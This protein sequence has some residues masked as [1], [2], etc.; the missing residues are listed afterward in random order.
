MKTLLALVLGCAF[1][2]PSFGLDSTDRLT[3]ETQAVLNTQKQ[4]VARWAADPVLVAAV[5]AQN[6]KGPLP[7]MTNRQ[8]RGLAP[9]DPTVQALQ[10]N[11]AGVWLTKKMAA[12]NGLFREAFLS[13]AKG[14]KVA[15]VEKPS[16]YLHAGM[17]KFDVPMSGQIW[18]GQP[19]FDKSSR[20]HVVQIAVPVK[21]SGKPIGVLVV[22]VSMKMMKSGSR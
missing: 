8:W 10:K 12:N 9:G 20:S 1:A 3:P 14:E 7:G 21:S 16:N 11:A 2:S 5:K 13:G 19:E 4:T 6:A 17:P 18:E 15:F 22:G